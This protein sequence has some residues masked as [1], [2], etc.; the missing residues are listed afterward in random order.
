MAEPFDLA[1]VGAGPGG[2]SGALRAAQ[3]GMR[4]VVVERERAGGLCG[5]W[6]CI[7]SKAILASAEVYQRALHGEGLGIVPGT[8]GFDYG[9]IIEHSRGA[10]ERVAK[11]VEGLLARAGVQLIQG[12]ARLDASGQ[13][14]VAGQ[15]VIPAARVL[16]AGGTVETRIEGVVV[17]PPAIVGSREF[18]ADRSLPESMVVIG[19]G[20]IGIEFAHALASLGV[21]VTV[22]EACPTILPGLEETLGREIGRNFRRRGIEVRTSAAVASVV[23]TEGGIVVRGQ[24]RGQP[25]ELQ[26]ERC[27]VAVGRRVDAEGLGLHDARIEMEGGRVRVDS[28]YRTNRPE[29][30]AVGDLLDSPPLAHVASAE[31]IA[32]VDILAGR[33]PEGRLDERRLPACVYVHPE[34]ASVGLSRREAV[35][36]GHAILEGR[37]AY[38]AL[39]RAVAADD[40]AGFLLLL[41]DAH[42]G[43]ILGAHICGAA[44]SDLVSE[45]VVAMEAEA[46]VRTLAEAVH[47]H[48]SFAEAIAEAARACLGQASHL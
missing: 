32:A 31:A 17:D 42:H 21:R 41:A 25:F 27:L 23:R 28:S 16:L 36:R 15:G 37:V 13:L 44:A 11:G 18:L 22:L 14:C 7:P 24:E 3:L 5:N 9:R 12:E 38:R 40:D 43:E 6:G 30:L 10:A 33:R 26:A 35:A 29:I 20:P 19:G 39:G 48:P 46:T 45:V 8:L 2:Y 1:V 47:P 4:V 34:I